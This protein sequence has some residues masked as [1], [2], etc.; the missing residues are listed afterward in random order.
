VDLGA[1]SVVS[2]VLLGM[3]WLGSRAGEVPLTS[4]WVVVA[5]A[6]VV[7]GLGLLCRFLDWRLDR[8]AIS[9]RWRGLLYGGIVNVV[10]SLTM[11][12]IGLALGGAIIGVVSFFY[13]RVAF[14]F[15]FLGVAAAG[16][17]AMR[18]VLDDRA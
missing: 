9:G 16:Y 7:L 2:L 11:V 15:A 4:P 12:W 8:M 1:V 13:G 10:L 3:C 14:G 18:L 5:G 6:G 17:V